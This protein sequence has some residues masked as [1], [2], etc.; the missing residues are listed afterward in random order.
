VLTQIPF[1][2]SFVVSKL[3]STLQQLYRRHHELVERYDISIS[4]MTRRLL[5]LSM[6]NTA[7]VLLETG[8]VYPSRGPGFTHGFLWGP[9][10]SS[11]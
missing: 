10:C 8:T 2:L 1:I 7:G 11:F 4:Q 3:K 6:S 9:C 5:Y